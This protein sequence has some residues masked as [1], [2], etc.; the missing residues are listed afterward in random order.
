MQKTMLIY[1]Q[2]Y[3]FLFTIEEIYLKNTES[4]SF[5]KHYKTILQFPHRI[6]LHFITNN[7]ENSRYAFY[8]YSSSKIFLKN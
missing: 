8:K 1:V 3:Q 4:K 6:R 5:E 2:K 7:F